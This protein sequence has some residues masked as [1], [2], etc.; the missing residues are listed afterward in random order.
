MFVLLDKEYENFYPKLVEHFGR[1]LLLKKSVYGDD[2]SGKRWH[3]ILDTFLTN[4]VPYVGMKIKQTKE[5]IT[6]D[7]DQYIKN[8]VNIFEKSFK[9]QF[10]V[11][12]TTLYS[13]FVPTRKDCP[14]TETQSK[15]DKLRF[16]N[17]HYRSVIGD[18]L[19]V[20][21]YTCPDMAYAVNKLVKLN[22][23]IS[24]SQ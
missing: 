22:S 7:Q 14:T 5:Y 1:P 4:D 16:G 17:L 15:E 23:W 13:N 18:L 6:L 3:G 11:K 2:F 12:D 20:S 24:I 19:Y 8:I 10:K 9:C 21:C